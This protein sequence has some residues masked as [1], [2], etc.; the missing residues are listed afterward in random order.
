MRLILDF[1]ND[2]IEGASKKM[3]QKVDVVKSLKNLHNT[4][5]LV[6]LI[7]N[8]SFTEKLYCSP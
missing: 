1:F 7:R 2:E 6:I 5:E 8:L 4:I 3:A